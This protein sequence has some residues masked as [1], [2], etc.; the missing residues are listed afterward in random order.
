MKRAVVAIEDKRFYQH[1]G[2]DLRGI[3]RA[4]FTDIVEQR[5]AQGASTI[6]QQFV[7]VASNDVNNR[8]VS[9]KIRETALAYHLSHKW[10]KDKILTE[11]LNAIYYGNGAY[12]LESAARTYFAAMNGDDCGTPR[13]PECA[14][15]LRPAQAPCSRESSTRRRPTTRSPIR[16][17]GQK[18]RDLVLSVMRQQ[19]ML[20][21]IQYQEALAE[22]IPAPGADQA[23]RL[24]LKDTGSGFFVG[25]IG[26]Q[27]V[28]KYGPRTAFEGG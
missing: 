2:V 21:P 18:R 4:A 24:H 3:A 9:A 20:N 17:R 28:K 5:A 14:Q 6:E 13:H 22:P 19:G 1:G 27:L 23:A 8:T 25:W 12:G 11:Y 16:R 10:S 26:A 15:Q 7:K